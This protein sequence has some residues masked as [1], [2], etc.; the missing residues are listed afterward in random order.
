L[1]T[2]EQKDSILLELL[3]RDENFLSKIRENQFADVERTNFRKPVSGVVS[4]EFNPAKGH[5]G[6]DIVSSESTPVLA[7]LDGTIVL[8]TWSLN[9]GYVIQIQ[10]SNN[11][12]SV[13]KHNSELLKKE[14]DKVVAGEPIAF[15]GSTGV[16]STGPH[17]HFEIWQDGASV[18][19]QKFINF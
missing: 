10:H 13:Y 6:I 2:Q 14:G 1:L 15:V 16:Q 5:F 7:T 11:I 8:A 9:N 3:D 19:P 18:N 17:L 12:I 4:N